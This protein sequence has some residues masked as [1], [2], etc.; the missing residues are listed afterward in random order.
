M[1]DIQFHINNRYTFLDIMYW[2]TYRRLRADDFVIFP[3]L[4]WGLWIG[5]DTHQH[6]EAVYFCTMEVYVPLKVKSPL[7][8]VL[9]VLLSASGLPLL[10]REINF[11][12][13]NHIVHS[14]CKILSSLPQITMLT[15]S[16]VHKWII[17]SVHPAVTCIPNPPYNDWPI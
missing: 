5:P 13:I 12:L 17:E 6:K 16:W 3:F 11:F 4:L 1:G 8:S 9:C 15:P 2:G 14:F 7:E 10:A